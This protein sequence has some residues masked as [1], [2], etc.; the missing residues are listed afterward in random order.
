MSLQPA[1]HRSHWSWAAVDSLP[2]SASWHPGTHSTSGSAENEGETSDR[3]GLF[4]GGFLCFLLCPSKLDLHNHRN[5]TW[6]VRYKTS[7]WMQS[8]QHYCRLQITS[9]PHPWS[10]LLSPTSS[11]FC[12][13]VVF[14]FSSSF[15]ISS[16]S[17]P[18]SPRSFSCSVVTWL[19]NFSCMKKRTQGHSDLFF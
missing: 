12:L 10:P 11:S 15:F 16:R 17:R 8:W 19:R 13:R 5:C 6:P 1:T 7:M 9:P 2:T 18:F 3:L 4:W 14:V